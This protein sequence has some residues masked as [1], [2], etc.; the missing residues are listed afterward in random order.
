MGGPGQSDLRT[1]YQRN[2]QSPTA[3]RYTLTLNHPSPDLFA[4]GLGELRPKFE[5]DH[6][7]A[8]RNQHRTDPARG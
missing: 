3:P 7:T 1:H 6:E 8:S 5:V 4:M 2:R